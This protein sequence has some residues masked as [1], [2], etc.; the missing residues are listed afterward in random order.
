LT[1]AIKL[2]NKL[3]IDFNVLSYQHDP[4]ETAYAKEAANKLGISPEQVFKTLV[5]ET[6]SKQGIDYCV[7]ILPATHQAD[8]KAVANAVGA[9]KAA[10][11]PA[12]KV[13]NMTG[14]ILGGVSP[15][16]QKRK[17]K[18]LIDQSAM[19]HNTVFVSAGKRGIEIEL[20][21]KSMKDILDASFHYICAG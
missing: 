13:Q 19:A 18:T 16:A 1:P 14:Y 7:T 15:F 3:K 11:A 4:K 10:L 5:F 12:N 21:P 17:L 20:E 6:V 2:L 9:K 8:L